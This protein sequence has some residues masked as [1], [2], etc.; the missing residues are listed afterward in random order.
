M[1]ERRGRFFHGK[2]SLQFQYNKDHDSSKLNTSYSKAEVYREKVVC[3]K[4]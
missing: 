2:R 3:G 4:F 1:R